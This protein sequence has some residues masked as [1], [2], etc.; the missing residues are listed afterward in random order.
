M[1]L[2]VKN[3]VLVL[4]ALL[5]GFLFGKYMVFNKIHHK[6]PNSNVIRSMVYRTTGAN[7]IDEYIKFDIEMCICPPSAKNLY[8]EK[9]KKEILVSNQ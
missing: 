8:K 1:W 2:I 6:G 9:M 5:T 3:T 7:G 4:T